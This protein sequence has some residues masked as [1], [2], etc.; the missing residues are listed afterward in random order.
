MRE[1]KS[2]KVEFSNTPCS[3]VFPTSQSSSAKSS[4]PSEP[5][6]S[7]L[8]QKQTENAIEKPHNG[9]TSFNP[10]DSSGQRKNRNNPTCQMRCY[11]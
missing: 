5:R 11:N 10:G 7:S 4:L 9:K 6:S 1:R 8:W 3:S 2:F